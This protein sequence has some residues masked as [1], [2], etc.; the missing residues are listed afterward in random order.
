MVVGRPAGGKNQP[1]H[2]AGG[3]RV[4]SG[5]KKLRIDEMAG[6]SDS[7]ISVGVSGSGMDF[8]GCILVVLLILCMLTLWKQQILAQ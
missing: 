5:R 4:N 6:E 1:G 7:D 3:S 8:G 2:N